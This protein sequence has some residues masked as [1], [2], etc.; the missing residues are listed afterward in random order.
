M[1]SE[2]F[3]LNSSTQPCSQGRRGG[4]NDFGQRENHERKRPVGLVSNRDFPLPEENRSRARFSTVYD[5]F[6]GNVLING[7]LDKGNSLRFISYTDSEM[8]VLVET[9]D[10]KTDVKSMIIEIITLGDGDFLRG[11]SLIWFCNKQERSLPLRGIDPRSTVK[12]VKER[13]FKKYLIPPNLVEIVDEH[14]KEV[15]EETSVFKFLPK[16][17][18]GK[19][20]KNYAE[21]RARI[22]STPVYVHPAI[23]WNYCR[24]VP[25]EPT[26]SIT[27]LK[28]AIAETMVEDFKGM[29][30]KIFLPESSTVRDLKIAVAK[31]MKKQ[32]FGKDAWGEEDEDETEKK[33]DGGADEGG[34]VEENDDDDPFASAFDDYETDEEKEEVGKA[35]IANDKAG[36][37]IP[38]K[39]LDELVVIYHTPYT[40]A[41]AERSPPLEVWTLPAGSLLSP[42]SKENSFN[43]EEWLRTSL[44]PGDAKIFAKEYLQDE[45]PALTDMMLIEKDDLREGVSNVLARNIANPET[46]NTSNHIEGIW[47]AVEDLKA[48]TGQGESQLYCATKVESGGDKGKFFAKLFGR[49]RSSIGHEAYRN[50]SFIINEE[51][52]EGAQCGENAAPSDTKVLRTMREWR[53]IPLSKTMKQA[54]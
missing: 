48:T 10:A 39:L 44:K 46:N 52:L 41:A 8:T 42:G 22:R 47:K 45:V 54:W 19:Q 17:A 2:G 53:L 38:P 11:V 35:D 29:D 3:T 40:K 16:N 26:S 51:A 31:R 36:C 24:M 9:H 6:T 32:W 18:L 33:A 49:G 34:G 4:E 13:L 50:S 25:C 30:L 20:C 37:N 1:V 15:S 14:G 5:F 23:K 27:S 12:E 21:I 7:T 43:Y 28:K